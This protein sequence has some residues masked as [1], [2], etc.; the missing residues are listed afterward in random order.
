MYGSVF[1]KTKIAGLS[2][3]FEKAA[4][5]QLVLINISPIQAIGNKN[6]VKA[7][8]SVLFFTNS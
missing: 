2:M 3:P 4:K 5:F 7:F 6:Q 1:I 8:N